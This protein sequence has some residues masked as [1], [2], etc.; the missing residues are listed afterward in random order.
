MANARPTGKLTTGAVGNFLLGTAMVLI[1]LSGAAGALMGAGGGTGAGI[2]G[3]VALLFVGG[4]GICGALGWFG[5]GSVYG[6]TNTL[7]GIFSILFA[8]HQAR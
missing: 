5:L 1:V 2:L 8:I 3:L 4:G 6:G 7:A